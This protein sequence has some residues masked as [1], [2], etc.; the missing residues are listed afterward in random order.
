MKKEE[1]KTE[2]EREG[3]KDVKKK[4]RREKERGQR[5]EVREEEMGGFGE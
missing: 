3:L 2:S 4:T 1:I 5:W